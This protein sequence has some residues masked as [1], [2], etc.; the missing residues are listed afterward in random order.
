MDRE[1]E[2]VLLSCRKIYRWSRLMKCNERSSS[3]GGVRERGGCLDRKRINN[4]LIMKT[5]SRILR[6]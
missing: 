1:R 3:R 2:A 5:S 6:V 4:A